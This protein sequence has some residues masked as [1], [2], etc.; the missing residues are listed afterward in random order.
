MQSVIMSAQRGKHWV[1]RS[2]RITIH[3][4]LIKK[5]NLAQ[6]PFS[7]PL[8]I[9]VLESSFQKYLYCI[10]MNK[11]QRNTLGTHVGESACH[12][13]LHRCS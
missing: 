11:Q 5:F 7:F 2:T 3:K 6:I 1:E 9:H 12:L 8:E 13:P 4:Y 10:H